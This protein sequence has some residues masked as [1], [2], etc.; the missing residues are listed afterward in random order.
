MRTPQRRLDPGLIEATQAAPQR[1]A[2]FQLVRL[3]ELAF[4]HRGGDPVSERIRFRSAL[5]LGF[6]PSQVDGMATRYRLDAGGQPTAE[7]DRVEITPAFI[8][9]LGTHGAL[10][11]HYTERILARD[12]Q[13]RDRHRA[14]RDTPAREGEARAFLDLFTNR[15]VGHF[16]RAWKKYQLP[17]QYELDRRNRFTPLLLALAGLGFESLR[18]RLRATP[19]AID[20]EAI[21]RLAGLLR[22]RPVSAEALRRALHGYFRETVAIEQFVGRWYPI[23]DTQRASLGQRAVRLGIDSLV[24]ERVWQRNLRVRIHLGPLSGPRYLDFLPSGDRAAALGKLLSLATGGQFEYEICPI[25]RAADVRPTRLG[26]AR[27]ARL[28]RDGF[29][30]TRPARQDRRDIRYLARFSH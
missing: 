17:V 2:F 11:L 19:G 24:G 9:M 21:A 25:L 23:P 18:G 26:G 29:L 27:P 7:P 14:Q 10:P 5:R 15:A 8:G 12:N 30:L 3:Y 28:G 4:R 13:L 16:Y 1:Y 22:Q 20:D 6:A